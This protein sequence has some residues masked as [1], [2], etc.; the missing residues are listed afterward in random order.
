MGAIFVVFQAHQHLA[1]FHFVAFF[2]SDPGHFA[3][4]FRS[5]LDFVRGDDVAG[6]VQ[7]DSCRR[8]W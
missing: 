8:R 7:D 6:G 3:D 2:D 5:Q 1:G 4:D